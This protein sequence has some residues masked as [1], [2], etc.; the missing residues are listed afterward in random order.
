[1]ESRA[2]RRRVKLQYKCLSCSIFFDVEGMG[3]PENVEAWLLSELRALSDIRE[4]IHRCSRARLGVG[5]LVGCAI[6][7][8]AAAMQYEKSEEYALSGAG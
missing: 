3:V 5:Q 1:M 4:A 8:E 2:G 7:E 6:V